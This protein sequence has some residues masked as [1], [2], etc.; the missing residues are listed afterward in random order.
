MAF[1]KNDFISEETTTPGLPEAKQQL[2]YHHLSAEERRKFDRFFDNLRYEHSVISTGR[3]EGR[4]EGKAEGKVEGKAEEKRKVALA[5]K[6]KGM[7]AAD[8]AEITELTID[9][10]NAIV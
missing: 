9:E 10:V 8:I 2:D 7:S 4:V 6:K 5:L 1:L 3:A